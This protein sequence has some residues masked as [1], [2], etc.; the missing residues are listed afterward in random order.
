MN[1]PADH[2][3]PE[4]RAL[5]EQIAA[6]PQSPHP[7]LPPGVVP[8]PVE[9]FLG[10]RTRPVA[11]AGVVENGLV[12]PLDPGVKLPERARVII[13]ATEAA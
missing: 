7:D 4:R 12:R 1:D 8:R 13:V 2:R 10:R 3:S 5:D 6:E 11:V 9:A